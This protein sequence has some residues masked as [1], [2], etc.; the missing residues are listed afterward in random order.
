MSLEGDMT[1]K[2]TADGPVRVIIA[3]RMYPIVVPHFNPR[4]PSSSADKPFI[5]YARTATD[6]TRT[7]GGSA[8]H[9][10]AS[11]RLTCWSKTYATS[12]DLATKVRAAIDNVKETWTT[13]VVQRCFVVNESDEL[14]PSPE[15]LEMQ[16]IGR[17]LDIDIAYSV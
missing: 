13:T 7:H 6:L 16:F 15:L 12:L 4:D 1:T 11:F 14:E 2:V 9:A 8:G 10:V 17:N 3:D 5:A